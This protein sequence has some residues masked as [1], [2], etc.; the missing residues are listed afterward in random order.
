MVPP[1]GGPWPR[2]PGTFGGRP[3]PGS[4]GWQEGA[5]PSADLLRAGAEGALPKLRNFPWG[6]ELQSVFGELR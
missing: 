3:L 6:K 5:S 2:R 1:E 4:R